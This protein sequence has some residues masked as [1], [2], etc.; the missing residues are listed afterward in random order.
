[1][2]HSTPPVIQNGTATQSRLDLSHRKDP[3]PLPVGLRVRTLAIRGC[4]WLEGLPAGLSCYE[5]D[6]RETPIRK[7]PADISVA[8]RLDLEDCTQLVELPENLK[9]G[10]LNLRGC[11]ALE[12]LP[13]GL[14]VN[15]LDLRG[16]SRLTGWPPNVKVHAGRLNLAGC[17]WISSLPRGLERVARL[18]ISDCANLHELPDGLEI[19]SAL[20]LANSGLTAL[21]ASLNAVPL[22]WHGVP[23]DARIAFFP[24]TITAQEV[25]DEPNA[26]RRRV[27]LER[28]GLERFLSEV[29]AEVLD[30]DQ[31]VGGR[32]RLVRV[33]LPDDEDLVAVLVHCPSTGG[34]YLL[35]VPP[36]M[37]T[38]RQAV[39]WTAGFDDPDAYRPLVEA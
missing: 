36:T 20:E 4:D 23:V 27:L 9:V 5:L 39:A 12:E 30:E 13:A 11:A 17:R 6:L 19:A 3:Y 7:L 38:C 34:R 21:P 26:E 32:R 8:F 31:D 28:V 29:D 18:D 33:P 1:M 2:V 16:C 37:A 25:L 24:E 35:R 22:R 10:T 15:F 14:D